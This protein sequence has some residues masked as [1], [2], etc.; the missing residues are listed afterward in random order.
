M[1]RLSL[2]GVELEARSFHLRDDFIGWV[3]SGFV[4]VFAVALAK[5]ESTTGFST[6]TRRHVAR[7]RQGAALFGFSS[8]E[9]TMGLLA[10]AGPDTRVRKVEG[11]LTAELSEL[12]DGWIVEVSLTVGA[13]SGASAGLSV[14]PGQEFSLEEGQLA[15]AGQQL[16]WVQLE[17]GV[18]V[19]LG[20]EIGS[21][22]LVP[23]TRHTWIQ[24][25]KAS[26]C[27]ARDTASIFSDNSADRALR[28]FHKRILGWLTGDVAREREAELK[29]VAARSAADEQAVGN[30]LTELAS[31]VE[32]RDL[33][34]ARVADTDPLLAACSLVG[35][36]V[37]IVI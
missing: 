10:V 17:E 18:G 35:Q 11:P 3:E 4:D 1:S 7:I 21:E 14:D 34:E 30:A 26:R 24:A 9:E 32:E 23:L 2:K 12:I 31:I 13:A 19:Y 37:G 25:R 5:D 28:D 20:Q 33:T 8:G 16:V 22:D 29:R 6:G 36:A 27:R 15:S